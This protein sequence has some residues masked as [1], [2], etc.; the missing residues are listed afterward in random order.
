M[1][2]VHQIRNLMVV[3]LLAAQSWHCGGVEGTEVI[4]IEK[5]KT[6]HRD[7][8]PPVHMAKTL[9]MSL[10]E[11]KEEKLTPCPLCQPDRL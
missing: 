11:A 5:T 9:T 2:G 7:G 3:S 6:Y 10:K 1:A 4:A 8:C